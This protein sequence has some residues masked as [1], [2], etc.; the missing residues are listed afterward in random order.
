M[1]RRETVSNGA[2]VAVVVAGFFAGFFIV[3]GIYG[4]VFPNRLVDRG[5]DSVSTA[6]IVSAALLLTGVG[7]VY[8]QRYISQQLLDNGA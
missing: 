4:F 7:G 3:A 6:Y 5:L 1:V 8:L 2:R